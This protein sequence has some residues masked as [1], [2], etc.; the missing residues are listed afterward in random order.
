MQAKKNVTIQ[1]VVPIGHT[2]VTGPKGRVFVGNLEKEVIPAGSTVRVE[3]DA[4]GHGINFQKCILEA[5]ATVADIWELAELLNCEPHVPR[6]YKLGFRIEEGSTYVD[7]EDGRLFLNTQ[8]ALKRGTEVEIKQAG[9][10]GLNIYKTA[11]ESVEC[12]RLK[13][14]AE[15]A[16]LFGV[17]PRKKPTQQVVVV[18][19]H[20]R[21]TID[22]PSSRD[23]EVKMAIA[24]VPVGE[25]SVGSVYII[26]P[27]GTIEPSLTQ[28]VRFTFV[29]NDRIE[30]R[31]CEEKPEGAIVKW[32]ELI[33]RFE[34]LGVKFRGQNPRSIFKQEPGYRVDNDHQRIRRGK[35]VEA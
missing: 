34:D 11:V 10:H 6:I 18:L 3:I 16:E 8:E 23:P 28:A 25:D 7:T 31:I 32:D 17:T 26:S 35:L 27:D 12:K 22:H 30:A 15:M 4:R 24:N 33:E 1:F 13:N 5:E 20:K 9:P 21:L 14:V 29:G 19:D 2:N